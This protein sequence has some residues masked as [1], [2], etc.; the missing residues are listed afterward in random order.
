MGTPLPVIA[1][2]RLFNQPVYPRWRDAAS[3]LEQAPGRWPGRVGR[4]A[5]HAD[6]ELRRT[7]RGSA[8]GR[9]F[10]LSPRPHDAGWIDTDASLRSAT[11]RAARREYRLRVRARY[12]GEP[13]GE[14][15]TNLSLKVLPAPWWSPGAKL[16]YFGVL[17]L[18]AVLAGSA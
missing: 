9:A 11:H 8:L 7:D 2:L 4:P 6:G 16:A 1:D 10:R 17:A 5:K 14:Q 15:E 3:P 12:A 18:L 13:W